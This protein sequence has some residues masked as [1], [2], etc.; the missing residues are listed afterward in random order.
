LAPTSFAASLVRI[1]LDAP[2]P[3]PWGM[4]ALI[5]QKPGVLSTRLV[6]AVVAV[7]AALVALATWLAR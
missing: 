2:Q 3:T 1:E 7:A 6:V 5:E 4:T